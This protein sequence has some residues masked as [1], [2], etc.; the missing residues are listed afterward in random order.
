MMKRLLSSVAVV[1]LCVG[2][3]VASFAAEPVRPPSLAMHERVCEGLTKN[4]LPRLERREDQSLRK[5]HARLEQGA[6][7]MMKHRP[8]PRV[9]GEAPQGMRQGKPQPKNLTEAQT[10]ALAAHRAAMETALATKHASVK[11]ALETLKGRCN[12]TPEERTQ[13]VQAFREAVQAAETQF[14]ASVK[15]THDALKASIKA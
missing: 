6:K 15:A 9:R 12:G 14:K 11:A 13:A 5:M 2:M 7:R 10:Q 4:V 1:S 8:A 3:P